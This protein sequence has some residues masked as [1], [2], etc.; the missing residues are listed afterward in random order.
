[1]T[2]GGWSLLYHLACNCWKRPPLYVLL[3]NPA[4]WSL[5]VTFYKSHVFRVNIANKKKKP[6]EG[7]WSC[8]RQPE[9]GLLPPHPGMYHPSSS[10]LLSKKRTDPSLFSRINLLFSHFPSHHL[11]P[12]LEA[13]VKPI[14]SHFCLLSLSAQV[15]LRLPGE[16]TQ[17]TCF[18]PILLPFELFKCIF[19]EKK[20][21]NKS[22]FQ[23]L[24]PSHYS[25]SGAPCN[26]RQFPFPFWS[27]SLKVHQWS[28]NWE[29]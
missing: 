15:C 13:W 26:P 29:M 22:C 6:L 28:S 24:E 9:L 3:Q 11:L 17:A 25:Y 4:S 20:K 23:W 12:L 10:P 8:W 27:W 19:L 1:M 16:R 2:F 7:L 14:P 18:Q 21:N 5:K